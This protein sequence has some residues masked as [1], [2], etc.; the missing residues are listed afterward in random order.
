MD[1]FTL[2]DAGVALIVIVSALLAYA[3][4]FVRET[5]SI[6]GW[7]L[8]GI[9]AYYFAPL[10]EPIVAELPV[11]RDIIGNSCQL[12]IGTS[13]VTV[14]A[15]GLVVLSI[16]TPLLANAVQDSA[17]GP[18]DSGAGFFFGVVR[19]VLIVAIA[20]IVYDQVTGGEAWAMVDNAASR[21]IL[22]DAQTMIADSLPTEVPPELRA[23]YDRLLGRCE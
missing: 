11:I 13:F 21:V 3:R 22:A 16:F 23:S 19:G 5:L 18:I 6:G 12:S 4:G 20:F 17:L 1:D 14:F 10:V 2:V 9:A 7:I 8:A 15:A